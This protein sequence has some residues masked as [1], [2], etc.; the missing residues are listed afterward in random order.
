MLRR[1][2]LILSDPLDVLD[3]ADNGGKGGWI[4]RGGI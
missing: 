3:A 2:P 4:L 1:G